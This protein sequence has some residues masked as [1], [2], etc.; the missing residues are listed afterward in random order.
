MS[1]HLYQHQIKAAALS[2]EFVG[3]ITS[4]TLLAENT[5]FSCQDKV[6]IFILIDSAQKITAKYEGSGCIL[7]QGSCA[8]LL[9]HCTGKTISEL[10]DFTEEEFLSLL[11]IDKNNRRID[12]FLLAWS[13]LMPKLK[14]FNS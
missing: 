8:V 1:Y 3:E 9:K 11:E 10:Q 13:V 4:P 14:E 12:C 2:Q 5:N 7:S 6:K